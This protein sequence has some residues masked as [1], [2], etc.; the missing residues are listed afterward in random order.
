[1]S[2]TT[3]VKTLPNCDFVHDNPVSAAYDGATVMGCWSFMC[4][5]HFA[6]YGIGLGTGKGQRLILESE[7]PNAPVG[8]R[9]V[10]LDQVMEAIRQDDNLGFCLKC[11]AEA[12][13]VEPDARKYEC[14]SC[15]AR[16]V[17]G[18]E[19]ILLMIA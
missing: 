3:Y 9:K 6:Q 8:R 13:G 14:E 16:A 11:G 17:Y 12:Q 19:E 1:M 10:T 15:G 5:E 7:K 18:A 2:D 4:E